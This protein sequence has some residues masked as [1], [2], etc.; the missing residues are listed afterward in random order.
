MEHR[1]TQNSAT[2]NK[3]K[4][5]AVISNKIKSNVLGYNTVQSVKSQ[6]TFRSNIYPLSFPVACFMLLSCLAYSSNLKVE[7]RCSFERQVHFQRII[8]HYNPGNRTLH[9]YSYENL[10]SYIFPN[11]IHQSR[12]PITNSA[13]H[14]HS[15][16]STKFATLLSL[17]LLVVTYFIILLQRKRIL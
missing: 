2:G 14:Q 10:K 3:K 7:V 13:D 9:N 5:T 11:I 12:L 6:P 4:K 17:S 8:W 16:C 15:S 1:Q